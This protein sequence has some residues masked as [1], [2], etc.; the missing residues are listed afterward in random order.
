MPVSVPGM[1]ITKAAELLQTSDRIIKAFPE[2]A[3]V[4]GKA[5]RAA[6]AT[7]PAPV[8]MFETIINLKPEAEWRAGVTVDSLVAEMDKALQFPGIS[9]AWTMPIKARIDMLSTGIRTPIGV[10]IYGPDL[11]G[12]DRLSR[13]IEADLRQVP[14]TSRAYAERGQNGYYLEI[15]PDRPALARYGLTVGD[16]QETIATALRG[17]NVT[18][19]VEGRQRHT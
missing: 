5:G 12:I 14:G 10:K 2:V 3:S 19:T 13:E 7:D 9:N 17:Q 15:T 16:L 4:F 6:T 1:S 18:T 8:E 11:P